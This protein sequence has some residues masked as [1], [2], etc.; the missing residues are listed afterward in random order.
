MSKRFKKVTAA[1]LSITTML[2]M[3]LTA[4]ADEL[5]T[6]GAGTG[7]ILAYHVDTY[8]VPTSISVALNPQ[9]YS[10]KLRDGSDAADKTTAQIVT[11]NYGLAN[12]S[13]GDK[14][15]K[16]T[17]TVNSN[18]SG[19]TFVD[20]AD[21]ATGDTALAGEYKMYLALV[22]ATSTAPTLQNDDPFKVTDA[23]SAT[24][25]HNVTAANMSDVKMTG[26]TEHAI[27]FAG[28][29]N[30]K[31]EKTFELGKATYVVKDGG[32]LTFTTTQEGLASEMEISAIGATGISGFTLTGAMNTKADWAKLTTKSLTFTPTYEFIDVAEEAAAAAA[33]AA[34]AA[35]NVTTTSI[36]YSKAN[37]GT[38]TGVSL[39]A[40]DLAA[41]AISTVQVTTSSGGYVDLDS[42]NW[43]YEDGSLTFSGTWG[44][45]SAGD[46]RSLKI[47]FDEGT[48]KEVSVTIAE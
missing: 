23:P 34:N 32:S 37:G 38:V 4:F 40:G 26:D 24:N 46:T 5:P 8:V 2:A 31:A 17:M 33:A 7:N 35:P 19:I 30:I 18:E 11:L 14:K 39:G 47:I 42:A 22:P 29:G 10:V 15:F 6:T 21:A 16:L 1:L 13:T 25:T 20:S 3:S 41:T 12:L 27:A 44:G 43:A 36:T 48:E 45:C 28:D 9:G